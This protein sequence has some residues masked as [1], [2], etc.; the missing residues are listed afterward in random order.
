MPNDRD[1]AR[2]QEELL[3]AKAR[4]AGETSAIPIGPYAR[5]SIPAR[6]PERNF[7]AEERREVDRMGNQHGCHTCGKLTPGSKLGHWVP[8]HQTPSA[9]SRPGEAQRLY[10]QCLSCSSRQG[11]QIL[12]QRKREGGSP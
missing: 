3:R 12:Q 7:S 8:D 11:G 10:P 5:E 6:G 9:L 2:V 1:V 4:A